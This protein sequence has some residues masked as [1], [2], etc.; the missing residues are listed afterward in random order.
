MS[1]NPKYDW[2]RLLDGI[3]GWGRFANASPGAPFCRECRAPIADQYYDVGGIVIC[4]TCQANWGRV[5]SRLFRGFN[6]FLL[7][8]IAAAVGAGVY[9]MVMFGTGWNFSLLAILIGYTVGGAVRSGSRNRGGLFYQLLAVYLTYSALVGM[10]L[11]DLWKALQARSETG[12]QATTGNEK[13]ARGPVET[14][15]GRKSDAKT[16]K[17]AM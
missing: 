6:A 4:P 9:R 11:P 5:R 17:R 7:G 2:R 10:F 8:S 15:P 1:W 3:P 16:V 12:K 14:E 13:D